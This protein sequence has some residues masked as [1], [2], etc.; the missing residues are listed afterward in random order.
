MTSKEVRDKVISGEIYWACIECAKEHR[1][2]E[3]YD[4]TYTFHEG[5][6]EICKE[7]KSIASAKKLFGHYKMRF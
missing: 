4:G 6:C 7:D 5:K 3:P 2:K 1:N